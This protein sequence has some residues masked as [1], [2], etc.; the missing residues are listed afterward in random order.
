MDEV[1][2]TRYPDKNYQL[3]WIRYYLECK[4][5]LNGQTIADV[6]D[7][8]VEDFYVKA[9]KFSL[10]SFMIFI[11]I[12]QEN[13]NLYKFYEEPFLSSVLEHDT[14]LSKLSRTQKRGVWSV[15]HLFATYPAVSLWIICKVHIFYF[16]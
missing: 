13:T 2:F 4:V 14:G 9:N 10:V 15:S 8:D 16:L 1:D 7:R 12:W 6:A 11:Q 5:E 3:E